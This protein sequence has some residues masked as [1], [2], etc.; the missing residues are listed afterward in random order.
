[1]NIL[2]RYLKRQLR[3]AFGAHYLLDNDVA[4]GGGG[5]GEPSGTPAPEMK[6]LPA[7]APAQNLDDKNQQAQPDNDFESYMGS[8]KVNPEKRP[9]KKFD[10]TGM[11]EKE[12]DDLIELEGENM[13]LPKDKIE[14]KTEPEKKE[15]EKPEESKK[16]PE[17]EFD[18]AKF[19]QTTGLTEEEFAQIPETLQEKLVSNYSK[20][21]AAPIEQ[22][23]QYITLKTEFDKQKEEVAAF[24][25]DPYVAARLEEIQTGQKYIAEELPPITNGE[26]KDLQSAQTVEELQEKLN[27]YIEQ[28]AETAINRERTIS[29][30]K[31]NVK[32]TMVK[33]SSVLSEVSKIDPRLA[34]NIKAENWNDIKPGH[35]DWNEFQKGPK[36]IVDYC[37]EKNIKIDAI[38]NMT[39]KELYAAI[40]AKEGW[41]KVRDVNIAKNAEKKFLENIKKLNSQ[42]KTVDTGR[43][44]AAPVSGTA[45]QM[46]DG[47]REGLVKQLASGDRGT[48]ERLLSAADGNPVE[49]D[50]LESI[51]REAQEVSRQ[52]RKKG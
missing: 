10:R 34:G 41:D 48:F 9:L 2:K 30:R 49:L 11:T 44:S 12:I 8:E 25:E 51:A 19:L 42:A 37:I 45:S 52:N 6:E 50:R 14:T 21:S 31:T 38:A 26:L 40:A 35:P 29:D 36:K 23:E 18:G 3:V 46:G 13:F 47:S 7:E 39:P 16:E 20:S 4:P 17:A 15:D 28:R 22:S 24:L 32:K 33:A 43:R 5:S 27:K 1:M